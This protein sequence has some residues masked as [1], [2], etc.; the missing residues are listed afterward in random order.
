MKYEP[1]TLLIMLSL[2]IITMLFGLYVTQSYMEVELPYN[3]EPPKMS[4]EFSVP[5]FIG[6]IIIVSIIFYVFTK[7]KF[8]KFLKLWFSIAIILCISV[9]LSLLIG[10]I[11]ALLVAAILVILRVK[12]KDLYIH[13]LTEILIYGGLVSF[14]L[15]LF[16]VWT[17]LVLLILISIYDYISVFITKHMILMAKTQSRE[18]I[19]T[20][21]MIKHADEVA[22][23]GGGDIAFT[24]LFSSIMGQAFGM[25]AAYLTVYLVVIA[26][27]V[28]TIIGKRGK[29]YPAM[30]Y[31]TSAC[32]ASLVIN[33]VI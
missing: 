26:L 20:G 8:T 29:F 19:F 31:L 6:A 1:I 3:I 33:L 13:N 10:D 16:N 22:I 21:L 7:L 5:Y 23:L 30:P 24:L 4:A 25:P 17:A 9:S 2:F 12:E 14:F 32:A 27:A 11:P 18:N 28:L 15:P